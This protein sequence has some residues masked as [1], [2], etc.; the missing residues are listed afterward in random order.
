MSKKNKDS[1]FQS[2]VVG[3]LLILFPLLQTNA[4]NYQISF[5]G[6]GA[7]AT[8]T[9]VKVENLTQCSSLVLNEGDIL[10]LTGTVGINVRNVDP[11]NN[12]RIYPNS[13]KGSCSIEFEAS[14]Q[15]KTTLELYDMTGKRILHVEELLLEGLHTYSLNGINSGIYVLKIESD[16]YSY[17]AKIACSNSSTGNAEIKHIGMTSGIIKQNNTSDIERNMSLKGSKSSINMQYNTGD[18]LKLT[19]KSGVYQTVVMLVPTQSQ[20]G[21]QL[22]RQVL[23]A[24]TLQVIIAAAF[25]PFRVVNAAIILSTA[26]SAW[27]SGGAPSKSIQPEHITATFNIIA[28]E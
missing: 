27:V 22:P 21:S 28:V 20:F 16:Q 14:A 15:G 4:Q 26:S 3:V 5:A 9:S 7:S 11:G 12:V 19:G 23:L 25:Q 8:V 24:S 1:I 2:V 17:N 13:M 6:K 10:N 18:N